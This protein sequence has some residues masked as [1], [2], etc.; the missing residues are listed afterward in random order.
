[1]VLIA[2][3]WLPGHL[4]LRISAGRLGEP[5]Q[6]RAERFAVAVVVSIVVTA[7][8]FLVLA[9]FGGHLSRISTLLGLVVVNG[10]LGVAAIARA[11]TTRENVAAIALPR[12][13]WTLGVAATLLACSIGFAVWA[14]STQP[15]TEPMTELYVLDA[16]NGT[17]QYPATVRTN[18]VVS[19]AFVLV[20]REG[21]A[22]TYSYSVWTEALNGT[23]QVVST[24]RFEAVADG[25][26]ARSEVAVTFPDPGTY[27][28]G[29]D[30]ASSEVPGQNYRSVHLWVTVRS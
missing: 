29:V 17:T 15:D 28:V 25:A 12:A 5:L 8:L 30:V 4:L 22:T 26:E 18:E 1:M 7:L 21:H 14:I 3:G 19:F 24:S 20:N 10:S 27:R 13:S 6:Q 11:E 16:A 2:A 9:L 23:K